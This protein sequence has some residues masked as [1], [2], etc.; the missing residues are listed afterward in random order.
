MGCFSF[1]C[2]VCGEGVNSSSFDGEQVELFLL[3]NGNVFQ[4]MSG[5]YD[6]YGRVFIDDTQR[7]GIKHPL[8]ESVEW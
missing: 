7:K 4:H 3:E 5:E 8:R 2:K 1:K 6:S